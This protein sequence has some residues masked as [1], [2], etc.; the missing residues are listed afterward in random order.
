[1][2]WLGLNRKEVR[3]REIREYFKVGK[4]ENSKNYIDDLVVSLQNI[5]AF[6]PVGGRLCMMNGDALMGGEHVQIIAPSLEAVSNIFDVE[7]VVMR[8]PKYTEATWASSQRRATGKLGVT[9]NDF[10]VTLKAK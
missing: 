8:V 7:S 2:A 1:M 5:R 10:I 6:L 9:M 3:K 4:P